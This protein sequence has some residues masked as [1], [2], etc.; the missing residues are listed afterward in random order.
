MVLYIILGWFLGIL[1]PV[2]T[3]YILNY[4]NKKTLQRVI[5]GELKDLKKRLVLLPFNI[6]SKYGT[7]DKKLFIWTKE[8]IRNFKEL[9]SEHGFKGRFPEIDSKNEEELEK[10]L[11]NMNFS[12]KKD[13]PAFHFKKMVT[14]VIDSNLMNIGML[15]NEFLT[16]LLDVKFQINA[17]NEEIQNVSEFLKMTFDSNITPTNHQIIQKEIDN[18]NLLISK[19]AIYIVEKINR[20]I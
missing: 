18:K 8:Q 9:E 19:K 15:D 1:S 4:Y 17:F 13:N 5:I 20:V 7:F 14:S 2:I 6:N 3:N 16:K 10:I 11:N 12:S